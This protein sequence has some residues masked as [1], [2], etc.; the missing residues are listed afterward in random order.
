[1]K[2]LVWLLAV[3]L[4]CTVSTP[5]EEIPKGSIVMSLHLKVAMGDRKTE[6]KPK[7]AVAD[8][9]SAELEVFSNEGE[10]EYVRLVVTPRLLGRDRVDL[11]IEVHS[12]LAGQ[13]IQRS[14]QLT[15]LLETR[16][17]YQMNN[18]ESDEKIS[19]SVEPRVVK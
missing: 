15:A 19:L 11:K 2:Y 3:I 1:M 5:A 6:M 16:S 18:L 17:V 9:R 4:L 10:E 13:S 12:R 14:L 7:V 8:G